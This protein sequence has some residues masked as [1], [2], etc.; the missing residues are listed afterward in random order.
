LS[1]F[2]AAKAKLTAYKL[3]EEQLYTPADEEVASGQI[4]R[5]LWAK[6][7]A[8]TADGALRLRENK[9]PSG[10]KAGR[11]PVPR[12]VARPDNVLTAL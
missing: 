7:T 1:L 4:R 5:G 12:A 11:P 8:E 10:A 9:T 6:A 2:S 3:A